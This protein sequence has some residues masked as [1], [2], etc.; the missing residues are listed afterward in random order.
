MAGVFGPGEWLA[1]VV[2]R[3]DEGAD[4]IGQFP[5]RAEEPCAG[6]GPMILANDKDQDEKGS[7]M[8]QSA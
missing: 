3:V 1:A 2:V 6:A 5:D 7:L 8:L 4:G